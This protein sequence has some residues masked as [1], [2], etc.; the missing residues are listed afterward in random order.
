MD[1]NGLSRERLAPGVT[2]AA[3]SATDVET[4]TQLMLE[5]RELTL[6]RGTYLAAT[7]FRKRFGIDADSSALVR[8]ES[9]ANRVRPVLVSVRSRARRETG[10][11]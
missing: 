2:G 5:L 8:P 4:M 9:F 6:S 7:D 1:C 11:E 10:R 3:F